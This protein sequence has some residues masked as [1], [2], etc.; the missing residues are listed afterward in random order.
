[1]NYSKQVNISNLSPF[2]NPFCSVPLTPSCGLIWFVL[3]VSY[4]VA[5]LITTML[6][7]YCR[8]MLVFCNRCSLLSESGIYLIYVS[9]IWSLII[10]TKLY[11][12]STRLRMWSWMPVKMR[13]LL[14]SFLCSF[15]GLI[16]YRN[17]SKIFQLKEIYRWFN[18]FIFSIWPLRSKYADL[19]VLLLFSKRYFP[20]LF[21]IRRWSL[22]SYA[23]ARFWCYL[24]LRL[25]LTNIRSSLEN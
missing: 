3:S 11:K 8:I 25:R 6:F 5:F 19:R 20:S 23:F 22:V 2:T 21:L 12:I 10:L 9:F 17:L 14:G 4:Q 7:K 1:M 15:I 18:A 16:Q 13:K 24:C